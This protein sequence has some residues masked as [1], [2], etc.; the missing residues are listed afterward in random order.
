MLRFCCRAPRFRGARS[1]L[2][3]PPR[4]VLAGKPNPVFNPPSPMDSI[5][6]RVDERESPIKVGIP[7]PSNSVPVLGLAIRIWRDREDRQERPLCAHFPALSITD[8]N[9]NV[10]EHIA[11]FV[12]APAVLSVSG[13]NSLLNWMISVLPSMGDTFA[14]MSSFGLVG[15]GLSR[16]AT[17]C[18]RPSADRCVW[19]TS[20]M[21]LL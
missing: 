2:A 17:V 4:N 12:H 6:L 7:L 5:F 21:N 9:H 3:S 8:G 13:R 20:R 11:L 18:G 16:S 15:F 10:P 1:G 14:D 19:P